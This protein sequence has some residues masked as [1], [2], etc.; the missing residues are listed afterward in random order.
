MRS[1]ALERKNVEEKNIE[2]AINAASAQ[3]IHV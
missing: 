1:V 2:R 3:A